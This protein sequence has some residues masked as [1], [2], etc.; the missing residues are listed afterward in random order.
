[1]NTYLTILP[2]HQFNSLYKFGFTRIPKE[3]L[4]QISESIDVE[5]ANKEHL[6]GKILDL[7]EILPPF[8]YDED[9]LILEVNLDK[10]F[11]SAD[12][13]LRINLT[14]IGKIFPLS[15]KA[16]ATLSDRLDPR[17][18]IQPPLFE[19]FLP[20]IREIID[21]QDREL[22]LELLWSIM[23]IK[24]SK[25]TYLNKF[26]LEAIREGILLRSK[27]KKNFELVGKNFWT[28]VITYDRYN[29]FPRE[30]VGYY[31]DLAEIFSN[32][33]GQPTLPEDSNLYYLLSDISALKKSES[34]EIEN[35]LI[36]DGRA[37]KFLNRLNEITNGINALKIVPLYLFLKEEARKDADSLFILFSKKND[38]INSY[39]DSLPYVLILLAY[40]FGYRNLYDK[41]YDY[42]NIPLLRLRPTST[43][44]PKVSAVTVKA[45]NQ[46]EN[47]NP[48]RDTNKQQDGIPI[49]L[50]PES[51]LKRGETYTLLEF[52]QNLEVLKKP[53]IDLLNSLFENNA[54]LK[55]LKISELKNMIPKQGNRK[56]YSV[57]N[58]K[59]LFLED[60]FYKIITVERNTAAITKK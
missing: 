56:S 28:L 37:S 23:E 33:Q 52:E 49:D 36:N 17:I 9:Y 2:R 46:S 53:I 12:S 26:N 10:P 15:E 30:K 11:N 31:F 16:K 29:H 59:K 40:F 24:E 45:N 35:I 51:E 48:E 39:S 13:V 47:T 5:N 60:G 21:N 58:I 22:A 18:I 41:I 42:V 34:K 57:E 20:E 27:G 44:K 19:E 8:E 55:Y 38:F 43:T 50:V 1:M 4:N 3:Y 14:E 54:N 7:F 25:E 6:F 32:S